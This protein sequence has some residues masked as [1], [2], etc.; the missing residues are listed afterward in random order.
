[1]LV[2]DIRAVRHEF[3]QPGQPVLKQTAVTVTVGQDVA[4]G[5][6]LGCKFFYLN[7]MKRLNNELLELS[8]QSRFGKFVHW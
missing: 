8:A 3:P 7:D 5:V 4:L 6:M 2:M 1:M